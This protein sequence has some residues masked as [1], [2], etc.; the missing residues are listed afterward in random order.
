MRTK[1][2]RKIKEKR[3]EI[4]AIYRKHWEAE[5]YF[6]KMMDRTFGEEAVILALAELMCQLPKKRKKIR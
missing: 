4:K 3:E 2:K 1:T 6:Q 5:R